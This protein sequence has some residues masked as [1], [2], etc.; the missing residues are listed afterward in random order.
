[1]IAQQCNITGCPDPAYNRVGV[2]LRVLAEGGQ[3]DTTN[4]IWSRESPIWICD[5]HTDKVYEV[6]LSVD[7]T[8][9]NQLMTRV[10]I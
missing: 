8:D 3:K 7:L 6:G 4:A 5:R 9:G 1:M 2:R 10:R